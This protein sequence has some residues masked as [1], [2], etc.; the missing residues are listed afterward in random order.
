MLRE[1]M[2]PYTPKTL[3]ATLMIL[4]ALAGFALAGLGVGTIEFVIISVIMVLLFGKH[5]PRLFDE[6]HGIRVAA[7]QIPGRPIDQRID[8]FV[9]AICFCFFAGVILSRVTIGL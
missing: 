3:I 6:S 9:L 1:T 4:A 2:L 7:L 8:W 5:I